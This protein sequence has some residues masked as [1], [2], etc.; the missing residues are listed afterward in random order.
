[1]LSIVRQVLEFQLLLGEARI[2][3]C[4]RKGTHPICFYQR[5]NLETIL[6]WKSTS[7]EKA[8]IC[9]E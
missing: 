2:P 9:G 4:Y 1:M 7:L 8:Y 5:Y 3:T 6:V